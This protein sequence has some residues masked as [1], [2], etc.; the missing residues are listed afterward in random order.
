MMKRT[1][2]RSSLRAIITSDGKLAVRK[3]TLRRLDRDEL[4]DIHGGDRCCSEIGDTGGVS[5]PAK[6][7]LPQ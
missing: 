1:R 5:P 6:I 3:T 7:E 2:A 4:S